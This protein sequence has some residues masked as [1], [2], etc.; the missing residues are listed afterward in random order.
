[1]EPAKLFQD[2]KSQAVRLPKKY[3]FSEDKVVIKPMGNAVVI[4]LPYKDSWET[5][6][7]SLE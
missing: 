6:F 5:L 2:G 3:R 7:N 4:F 1:M